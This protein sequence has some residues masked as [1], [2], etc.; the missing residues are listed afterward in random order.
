M[1]LIE[2]WANECAWFQLPTIWGF[3]HVLCEREIDRDKDRN[4]EIA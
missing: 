2:Q 1:V 4:K 3:I